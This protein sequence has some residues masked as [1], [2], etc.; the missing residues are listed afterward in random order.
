MRS[1]TLT[2]LV[3]GAVLAS[4]SSVSLAS[5]TVYLDKSSFL[6]YNIVTLV[7]D[8]ESVSP[9]D[10]QIQPLISNG[11]TY[12]GTQASNPNVWVTSYDYGNFG[13]PLAS[14][15]VLTANGNEEFTVDLGTHAGQAVGFDVYFN[16]LGPLTI[17][18]Y[19]SG[20]TQLGQVTVSGAAG[21][22]FLGITFDQPVN[23]FSWLATGGAQLNTGL[24]N[25]YTGTIPAPG[26][27]LLGSLGAGLVGWLRRRRA[28]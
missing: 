7:E 12:T 4:L 21:T 24:D 11:V 6:S 2:C 19:G 14:P 27:I 17:D 1:S 28:L 5:P 18:Y 25:L 15:S 3:V 8:F 20:G 9:K 13:V 22:L 23:S 10:T 16:G 26:A